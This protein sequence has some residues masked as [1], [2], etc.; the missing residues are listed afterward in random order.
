M[1]YGTVSTG[2]ARLIVFLLFVPAMLA[3][4]LTGNAP[5]MRFFSPLWLLIF[6]L[7]YG[8]GCLLIREMKVRWDLQWGVLFLAVAYGIVEEGLMTKA[9]FN[10][11]WEGVGLLS[12]YGMYWGVQWVWTLGVT[13]S[14][15]T[16]SIVVPITIADH[17][18]PQY[19]HVATL[20]RRGVLWALAG[21]SSITVMGTLSIGRAEGSRTIPFHPHPVLLMGACL[22]V[23]LLCW[24]AYR[25]RTIRVSTDI[26]PLLP[27]SAFFILAF[28]VI[29]FFLIVPNLMA[30]NNAPAMTAIL[31]ELTMIVLVLLFTFLQLC[32][33][34]MSGRHTTAL[35]LGF[36][37]PW[38]LLTPFQEF[39]TL[40]PSKN[41]TG[42]LAVGIVALIALLLWRR[43]VLRGERQ[44]S[45]ATESTPTS[46]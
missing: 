23:V 2:N 5:P 25:S 28:L 9:F 36:L 21:I 20:R 44:A 30:K 12:G 46:D 3:E 4:L 34:R 41:G 43:V 11:E 16:I 18:W 33:H 27:P 8:C 13:F 14:H 40:T 32:H 24:L 6:V 29:P 22:C 38:I 1:K 42:M 10:P 15:A 31:A 35:V 19:R 37:M 39:G 45:T 7:L 17:L 26:V